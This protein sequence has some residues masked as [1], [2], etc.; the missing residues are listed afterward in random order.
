VTV[1]KVKQWVGDGKEGLFFWCPG[2]DEVHQIRT[3]PN[4]WTFNGDF[5]NPTFSPSVLVTGGHFDQGW[6]GPDCWCSYNEK[7][8]AAG[9]EPSRFKCE[10]C[11]SFVTNGQI[12]FL[13]DCSHH[14]V[15]QTVPLPP[16]PHDGLER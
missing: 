14:L 7:E 6:K 5:E 3:S 15:N 4:G 9:R 10:R 13:S 8:I 11:H 2:C 12:Q 1:P 16:W